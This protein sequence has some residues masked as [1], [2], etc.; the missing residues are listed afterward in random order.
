MRSK[1]L[2]KKS[3][4]QNNNYN[5]AKEEIQILRYF[6]KAWQMKGKTG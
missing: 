3:K 2:N 1:L 6:W 4:I 5:F